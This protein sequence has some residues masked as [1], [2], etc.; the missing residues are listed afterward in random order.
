V[1]K[2]NA[3]KYF[4]EVISEIPLDS[5]PTLVTQIKENPKLKCQCVLSKSVIAPNGRKALLKELN[6]EKLVQ[7]GRINRKMY[8]VQVVVVLNETEACVSFP[9]LNGKSD[10]TQMLYGTDTEFREWCLDFFRYCWYECST[11]LENNVRD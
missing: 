5:I 6:F 3:K 1:I 4:Y 11:F 2:L 7:E 8:K 9:D 10:I